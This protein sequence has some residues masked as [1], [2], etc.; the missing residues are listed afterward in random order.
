MEFMTGMYEVV[1]SGETDRTRILGSDA[2]NGASDCVEE[3]SGPAEGIMTHLLISKSR[4]QIPRR[5]E[6]TGMRTTQCFCQGPN[7]GARC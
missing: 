2:T 4:V 5:L 6:K 7:Q 3:T 1:K